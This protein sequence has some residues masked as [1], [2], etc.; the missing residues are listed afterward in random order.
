MISMK[1]S[2]N[3]TSRDRSVAVHKGVKVAVYM[4]DKTEL[5]LTRSDLIELIN[6]PI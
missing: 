5:T 4:V 6:V 2:A 3:H 1:E